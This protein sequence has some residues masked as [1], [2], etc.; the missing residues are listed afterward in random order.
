VVDGQ[1]DLL[2][3]DVF[4]L[5]DGP[6]VLDC[7]EFDDR[8][9]HLDQLDDVCCLAMDLERLGAPSAAVAFLDEYLELTGDSA[10]PALLHHFVAYRAFVRAKVG[11]LPG[12]AGALGDAMDHA[13]LCLDHL[14]WGAVRLV[15]V[16]GA[17]GSGKST[18]AGGVADRLGYVTINSDRVRKELAGLDPEESAADAFGAGLYTPE[19]SRRTYD[20]ML[21]RARLLLGMGESVVL[22]ATWGH[23]EQRAQAVELADDVSAELVVF[24]CVLSAEETDRRISARVGVSDADAD[25]ADRLRAEMTPWP[26]GHRIDTMGEPAECVE[27][28]CAALGV[29]DRPR[30]VRPVLTP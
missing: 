23:D 9:R 16:G 17:P 27:R 13:R 15:V 4:C 2:A 10:P 5:D 1:G 3:E 30:V 21:R 28:V 8:L 19:W 11:C 22:D 20:E 14:R 24:E 26:G 7:L 29:G 12:A 18:L 6:R 25:I